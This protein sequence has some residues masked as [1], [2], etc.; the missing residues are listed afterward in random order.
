MM[1]NSALTR[2]PRISLQPFTLGA[3]ALAFAAIYSAPTQASDDEQE[4]EQYSESTNEDSKGKTAD[5]VLQGGYIYTAEEGEDKHKAFA[6]SVAIRDKKIIFV[7]SNADSRKY[8]GKNTQVIQLNGKMVLPGLIDSHTHIAAVSTSR[9][10]NTLN[11]D[12][13]INLT[14]FFT[15]TDYLAQIAAFANSHPELAAIQGFNYASANFVAAGQKPTAE[16]LDSVVSDRPAAIFEI[17]AHS[18]WVNT[19]ALAMLGIT[20]ATPNPP[21]GVIERYPMDYPVVSKR[22]KA[23]GQLLENAVSLVANANTVFPR[24]DKPTFQNSLKSTIAY[25]NSNGVT[26][27]FE[28][29]NSFYSNIPTQ[30]YYHDAIQEVAAQ[31]QLNM[32][33]RGSW[34][35]N[36]AD[37]DPT[38]VNNS[39]PP[40]TPPKTQIDQ[41]VASSLA[42]KSGNGHFRAETVKFFVDGIIEGGDRGTALMLQPYCKTVNYQTNGCSTL[43]LDPNDNIT[44]YKGI[45]FWANVGRDLVQALKDTEKANFQIHIHTIGDGAVRKATDALQAAKIK[46]SMYPTLAHMQFSEADDIAR[47]AKLGVTASL[48]LRW[49]ELDNYFSAYYYPRVG[50][51]RAYQG[52]YDLKSLFDLGINVATGSDY[53]VSAPEYPIHTFTGLTRLLPQKVY[54]L[55][56][57]GFEQYY[58]YFFTLNKVLDP[59]SNFDLAN[60]SIQPVATLPPA[61]ERVTNLEDLIK[62]YTINPA[63]QLLLDKVTG[64]IKK[65]K[66]ADLVVWDKNWFDSAAAFA[67]TQNPSSL[68]PIVN[69]SVV[70]TFFE[71]KKVYEKIN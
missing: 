62:S 44:P 28:A 48:T 69:S 39:N 66:S 20:D 58:P 40:L 35:V 11:Q 4:V 25:F 17:N 26:G 56:Y 18:T 60:Y 12:L 53:A 15:P 19:K 36:P 65:G 47:M 61:S 14:S 23:T 45:D 59:I 64:S 68:D 30:K 54:D 50:F 1:N 22:G 6:Q 29:M 24:L 27:A 13:Q 49:M 9:A 63:K 34:Y 71:G 70:Y 55:W 21:N 37:F 3:L 57:G 51:N 42:Y 46:K 67:L 43:E 38:Q 8:I 32:R 10:K 33:L 41:A 7:G 52:Q 16:L 2:L 5:T 31:N